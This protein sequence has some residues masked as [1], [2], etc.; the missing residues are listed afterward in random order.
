MMLLKGSGKT[1]AERDQRIKQKDQRLKQ[2]D[3]SGKTKAKR[4]KLRG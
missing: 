1:K 3:Q 2:K 4:L